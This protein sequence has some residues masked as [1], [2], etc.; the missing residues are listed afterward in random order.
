MGE[1]FQ[2][3]QEQAKSAASLEGLFCLWKQAHKTE[4]SEE[5]WKETCPFDS[6]EKAEKNFTWDG[7][8]GGAEKGD[9]LFVC[10]ESNLSQDEQANE[11]AFW[12]QETVLQN[13]TAACD[14]PQ[15]KRARTLY[16]NRLKEILKKLV[17]N[18]YSDLQHLEDCA[19]MNLNKRGG[20][21]CTS[22]KKLQNY[23][24]TYSSFITREMELLQPKI[25]VFCGCYD[26]VAEKLFQLDEKKWKG[27]PV[28]A[29]LNGNTVTLFYVYHPACPK[30]Q[31][32]LE[33]IGR[34]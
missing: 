5:N 12:M 10:K 6:Q 11:K 15:A 8:L 24:K 25:I 2:K 18:G 30:F 17:E 33:Y 21:N 4:V 19:Y 22:Y 16:H 34:N 27:K 31:D 1:K 20:L 7:H 23:I 32:S 13:Y 3:L 28:Q 14:S 9:V 29:K 26:G